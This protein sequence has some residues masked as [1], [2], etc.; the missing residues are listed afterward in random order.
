M[1]SFE[2]QIFIIAYLLRLFLVLF[3]DL[4]S[5]KGVKYQDIDYEMFTNASRHIYNGG[6]A[7][8]CDTYRYTPLLAWILQPN[9]WFV[10]YFGK[11][12]FITIDIIG[13][14]LLNYIIKHH[15]K[16]IHRRNKINSILWIS[17]IWLFNPLIFTI[18]S[19]G[20]C[21]SIII[22]LVLLTF[23]LILNEE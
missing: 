22:I 18:S 11:L 9:I 15:L 7:F 17:I 6:I 23:Y 12:L 5:P 14:H 10:P 3:G 1:S 2:K 19:R 13:A 20:S 8:D 4:F 16:Q 21:D